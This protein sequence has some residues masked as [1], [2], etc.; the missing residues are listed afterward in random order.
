MSDVLGGAWRA[1]RGAKRVRK[2]LGEERD[3]IFKHGRF[4]GD[5]GRI[6][7]D[8][9][10]LDYFCVGSM[11]ETVMI[12]GFCSLVV[13]M[14]G[15]L[16]GVSTPAYPTLS[17]LTYGKDCEHALTKIQSFHIIKNKP[18][19]RR[20]SKCQRRLFGVLKCVNRGNTRSIARDLLHPC[21]SSTIILPHIIN[22][23]R[24]PPACWR[25]LQDQRL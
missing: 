11:V 1:G 5:E 8:E 6:R 14:Y 17:P 21:W 9:C 13:L 16:L 25:C 19:V 12:L 22:D 3:Y 23:C 24:V 4:R 2:E 10:A 20:K 7:I 18:F 15:I